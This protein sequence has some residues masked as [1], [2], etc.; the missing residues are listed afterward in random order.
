MVVAVGTGAGGS[1]NLVDA[2]LLSLS[3]KLETMWS[4]RYATG[5]SSSA[6]TRDPVAGGVASRL[7]RE[8]DKLHVPYIV[9]C[10][11]RHLQTYG[12]WVAT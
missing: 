9:H 4:D 6:T 8:P 11:C 3:S 12:G 1:S 2:L 10:C 5:S 7:Q